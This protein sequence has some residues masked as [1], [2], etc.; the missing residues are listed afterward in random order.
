MVNSDG[1]IEDE[2][3]D[4]YFNTDLVTFVDRITT[5]DTGRTHPQPNLSL[6]KDIRKA[7]VK[8]I[9][10]LLSYTMNPSISFMQTLVGLVCY[11][12]G[13]QDAGF[14]ILNMLGITCSV[15]SVRRHGN[16]WSKKRKPV[17]ELD[18]SRFW[19]VSIDNL[20]FKLKYAKN[21]GSTVAGGLKNL[22]TG[23]VTTHSEAR[24]DPNPC[25]ILTLVSLAEN[26]LYTKNNARLPSEVSEHDY[27]IR[28][29]SDGDL[30]FRRFNFV[31]TVQKLSSPRT[32]LREFHSFSPK[33]DASLDSP[34]A[35]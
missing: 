16:F 4:H 35:R 15:D 18:K 13:L 23:Q 25:A 11:S 6:Y 5:S 9:V 20:D 2:S 3:I 7:W 32:G 24:T 30:T 33:H 26:A 14:K 10:A 8:M 17:D 1:T 29:N 28:N 21:I 12:F 19:R 27:F 31:S 22:I 34:K